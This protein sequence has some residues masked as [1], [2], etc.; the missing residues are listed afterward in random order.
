MRKLVTSRF[1]FLTPLAVAIGLFASPAPASAQ[2][3]DFNDFGP[4]PL[5][6]TSEE[7]CCYYHEPIIVE[8]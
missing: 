1:A 2:L 5:G 6:C 4:C 8:G 7:V 3:R